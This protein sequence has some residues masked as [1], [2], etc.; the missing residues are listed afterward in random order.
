MSDL[1]DSLCEHGWLWSGPCVWCENERLRERVGEL[2]QDERPIPGVFLSYDQIDA[3]RVLLDTCAEGEKV[4]LEAMFRFFNILRC[5][6]CGGSGKKESRSSSM[7]EEPM[8]WAC[9]ACDGHRW[10][11]GGEDE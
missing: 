11:I 10:T 5:E 4:V 8:L 2:E 9:P 7:K 6:G 3:A 1:F